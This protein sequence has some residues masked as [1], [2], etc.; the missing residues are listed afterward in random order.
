MQAGNKDCVFCKVVSGELSHHKVW[1]S[2]DFVAFLDI[3]PVTPGHL[4]VVPKT[5]IDSVFDLPND[6]YVTLFETGKKLAGPLKQATGCLKVGLSVVGLD[7][8]HTHLHVMPINHAGDADHANAKP[9]SKEELAGM[10][11]KIK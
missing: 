11:A 10:Q 1:E 4:L 5:H 9:A 7:V 8:P 2:A 6:L 3:N